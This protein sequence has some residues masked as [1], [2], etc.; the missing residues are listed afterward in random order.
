MI[1]LAFAWMVT[2]AIKSNA[3]GNFDLTGILFTGVLDCFCCM[4]L[5]MGLSGLGK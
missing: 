4:M 3:K 5:A 1:S 2:T